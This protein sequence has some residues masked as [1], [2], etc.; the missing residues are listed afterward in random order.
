M[1]PLSAVRTQVESGVLGM[2][3]GHVT[4]RVATATQLPGFASPNAAVRRRFRDFVVRL[5][6][7]PPPRATPACI[8][9]VYRVTGSLGTQ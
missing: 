4:Y 9:R 8:S 7:L 2:Q 1:L 6:W 3:G 5:L